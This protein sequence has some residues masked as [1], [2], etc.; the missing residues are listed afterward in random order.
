MNL[1]S[2]RR[3]LASRRCAWLLAWALCL[4]LAQAATMAH[5]LQHLR[6]VAAQERDTPAQLPLAACDLCLAAAAIGGAAPAPAVQALPTLQ[7]PHAAPV[8]VPVT[9]ARTQA[10]CF[11]C[12]RAPPL[13]HA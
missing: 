11:Y 13:L 5:A 12:T 6:A 10:P 3:L 8:A 2:M 9:H 7:L 1:A 4:P